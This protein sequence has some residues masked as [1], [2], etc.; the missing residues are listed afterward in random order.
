MK[1]NESFIKVDEQHKFNTNECSVKFIN[2]Y[3]RAYAVY[4]HMIQLSTI[5]F[6]FNFTY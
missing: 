2:E 3:T 6:C 5:L 1:W 4:M